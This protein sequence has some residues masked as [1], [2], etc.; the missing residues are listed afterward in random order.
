VDGDRFSAFLSYL[1]KVV[2]EAA[3]VL[4]PLNSNIIAAKSQQAKLQ[5]ASEAMHDEM[6]RILPA[7][8]SRTYFSWLEAAMVGS[9]G[10][11]SENN[12]PSALGAENEFFD[13]QRRI[14]NTSGYNT[15]WKRTELC[16]PYPEVVKRVVNKITW[17]A[18]ENRKFKVGYL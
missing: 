14:C 11:V 9:D 8:Y 16:L 5:K 3:D 1:V 15:I 10:E 17:N 4:I 6:R 18:S 12:V 7:D 2:P 13:V